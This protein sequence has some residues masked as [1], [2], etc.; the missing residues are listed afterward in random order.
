GKSTASTAMRPIMDKLYSP[1]IYEIFST[2]SQFPTPIFCPAILLTDV[3]RA[4]A[5]SVINLSNRCAAPK[6]PTT[7]LPNEVITLRL[8]AEPAEIT[9]ICKHKGMPK[10]K[11]KLI[12]DIEGRVG[13]LKVN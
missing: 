5:G 10:F 9:A 11:I 7:L 12:S 1:A 3:H 4:C 13:S 2:R 8:A 6:P